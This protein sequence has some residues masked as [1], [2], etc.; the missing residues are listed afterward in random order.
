[1]LLMLVWNFDI[2]C[3]WQKVL[4]QSET[5]LAVSLIQLLMG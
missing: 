5:A 3:G 1:M 2:L 4:Q